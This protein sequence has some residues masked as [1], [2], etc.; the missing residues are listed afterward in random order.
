MSAS[1]V[2]NS[3]VGDLALVSGGNYTSPGGSC[4]STPLT[5]C[6]TAPS[7]DQVSLATDQSPAT[8]GSSGGSVTST[9][10]RSAST[11]FPTVSSFAVPVTSGNVM[12]ELRLVEA[13]ILEIASVLSKMDL[14]VSAIEQ[15][16]MKRILDSIVT[17][18]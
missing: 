11:A 1:G 12:Q 3:L 4:A 2:H 17:D 9:P 15:K 14:N 18:D 5:S 7:Y 10:C 13:R 16:M 8:C 6:N